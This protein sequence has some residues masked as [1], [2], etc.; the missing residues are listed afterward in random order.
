MPLRR[1]VQRAPA[2][3]R[4]TA[5]LSEY[6]TIEDAERKRRKGAAMAARIKS[7]QQVTAM[8]GPMRLA[9]GPGP[10]SQTSVCARGRITLIYRSRR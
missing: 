9:L 8:E 6:M 4:T 5:R 7:G 10:I 3:G 2:A 1:R